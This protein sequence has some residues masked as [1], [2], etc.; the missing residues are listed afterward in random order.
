[1]VLLHEDAIWLWVFSV[2][3][4]DIV[5]Y[6]LRILQVFETTGLFTCITQTRGPQ[7]KSI[8]RDK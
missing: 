8:N 1:M 3:Y 6:V 2:P 7:L 4:R 5:A